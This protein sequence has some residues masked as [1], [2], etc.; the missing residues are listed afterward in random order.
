M[1]VDP[2]AHAQDEEEIALNDELGS[3][4]DKIAPFFVA[5]RDVRLALPQGRLGPVVGQDHGDAGRWQA[6]EEIVAEVGEED[7]R[8][9]YS[10]SKHHLVRCI[11][12]S[13]VLNVAAPINEQPG[14]NNRED[15][16]YGDEYAQREIVHF[17]AF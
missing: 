11:Q 10:Q 12:I 5:R 4:R 13:V 6:K 1:R 2:D 14:L 9:S 16:V 3:L 15:S 7:Q 8:G 17:G